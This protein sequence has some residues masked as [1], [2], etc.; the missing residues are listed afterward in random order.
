MINE[1]KVQVKIKQKLYVFKEKYFQG[2]RCNES[3]TI[4]MFVGDRMKC[5][6]CRISES[7]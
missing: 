2:V 6:Q 1:C 7:P 5:P 4:K 3:K